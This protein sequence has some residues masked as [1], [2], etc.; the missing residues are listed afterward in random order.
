M[1]STIHAKLENRDFIR[2]GRSRI[3]GTGVFAKRKIPK[4][5]RII[6]YLGRRIPVGTLLTECTEGEP[7]RTYSFGVNETTMIDA[8]VGGNDARFINHSCEPNCEAYVFEDRVYIYAMRDITRNEEL[9]FDYKLGPAIKGARKKYDMT[10]FA[11]NC[12]SPHCR[13]TMLAVTRK[14]T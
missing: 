11:C 6:E 10:R 2:V 3:E 14:P 7:F 4:G 12:G 5:T 13:G 8:T 9:T 1:S